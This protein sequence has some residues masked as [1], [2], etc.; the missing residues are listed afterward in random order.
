MLSIVEVIRWTNIT[1]FELWLHCVGIL[2]FSILLT[3]KLELY[4]GIS[5]WYVFTPLFV[6]SA[7]NGYFLFIVFVRTIIDEKDCKAPFLKYAFSWLRLVM[8]G[9]FEALLCYKINGDLEDGQVA[10]QS[11][12]G[13]IFL[14]IW[15]LMAAL[16]F[17]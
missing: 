15:V 2:I 12:Y 14:P 6:A 3:V 10:V 8:L 7:F 5:Y 17:Q 9:V 1:I 4:S 16:C 11:S 13:V